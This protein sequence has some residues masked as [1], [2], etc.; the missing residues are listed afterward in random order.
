MLRPQTD[1]NVV[2]FSLNLSLQVEEFFRKMASQSEATELVYNDNK[3]TRDHTN[4]PQ[5]Q[6]D[7]SEADLEVLHAEAPFSQLLLNVS[8]MY[9]QSITLAKKMQQV[10]GHSMVAFTAEPQPSS[11]SVTQGAS[12]VDFSR[13]VDHILDSVYDFGT[14]MLEEFSYTVADVFEEIREAEDYLQHSSRGMGLCGFV[15]LHLYFVFSLPYKIMTTAVTSVI[16]YLS[17]KTQDHSLLRGSPRTDIC[18]DD[19]AD[20]H[21]TAPR[22]V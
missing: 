17:A 6:L 16:I 4:S 9:N 3:E 19:S 21:P 8:L 14:N 11:L 18:A 10:F 22:L 20:K 12:N 7:E 15:A 1:P 13:T 5:N 2:F